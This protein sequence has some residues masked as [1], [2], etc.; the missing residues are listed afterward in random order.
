MK[1]IYHSLNPD[2]R[3]RKAVKAI[4][5]QK[6]RLIAILEGRKRPKPISDTVREPLR[7]MLLNLE[8][9]CYAGKNQNIEPELLMLYFDLFRLAKQAFPE[10]T[11]HIVTGRDESFVEAFTNDIHARWT[12]PHVTQYGT[13]IYISGGYDHGVP[14]V[15]HPEFGKTEAEL[16]EKNRKD[17][18]AILKKVDKKFPGKHQEPGKKHME[19]LNP[20]EGVDIR[21]LFKY[22]ED[23]LKATNSADKGLKV[24]LSTTGVDI[25]PSR[26]DPMVAVEKIVTKMDS[27]RANCAYFG[28]APTDIDHMQQV[29][30]A[31]APETAD[32]SVKK[33]VRDR[34][35]QGTGLIAPYDHGFG[36]IFATYRLMENCI[37][38]NKRASED[39][40]FQVR[41]DMEE[42]TVR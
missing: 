32:Q 9:T 34:S 10:L 3:V 26:A 19:T 16:S 27:T 31:V 18:D 33:Y 7:H 13:R 4:R 14:P 35:N 42:K 25:F 11:F 5:K 6:K 12:G 17:L 15:F 40:R 36:V 22:V 21:D 8:G 39:R 23:L 29:A 38:H 28:D 20:P 37:W 30:Y 1:L 41:D 24:A 2:P